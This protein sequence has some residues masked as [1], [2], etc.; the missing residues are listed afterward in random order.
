MK[1]NYL[2]ISESLKLRILMEKI[3]PI[4]LKLINF[5]PN[6]SGCYGLNSDA[7]KVKS[8]IRKKKSSVELRSEF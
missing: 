5:T 8:L 2:G 6:T 1:L 3:L 4:A 7:T